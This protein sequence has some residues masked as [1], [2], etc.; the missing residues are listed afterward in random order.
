MMA[1]DVTFVLSLM[2]L[3]NFFQK[4]LRSTQCMHRVKMMMMTMMT[5]AVMVE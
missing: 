2:V 1:T 3:N 4:L 5:M